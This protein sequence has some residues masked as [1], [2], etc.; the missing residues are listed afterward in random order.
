MCVCVRFYALGFMLN[1][2]SQAVLCGLVHNLSEGKSYL[3]DFLNAIK[4]KNVLALTKNDNI[5][6]FI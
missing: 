6:S 1:C 3:R 4:S 2:F 5:K